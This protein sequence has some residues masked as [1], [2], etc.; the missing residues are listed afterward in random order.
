MD[1]D[2]FLEII[3]QIQNMET[4]DLN[5]VLTFI[6]MEQSAK[7]AIKKDEARKS[8]V[9][10]QSEQPVNPAQRVVL[11]VKDIMDKPFTFSNATMQERVNSDGRYYIV[12]HGA[13]FITFVS[14]NTKLGRLLT[15]RY[16]PDVTFEMTIIPATYNGYPSVKLQTFKILE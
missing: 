11:K 7:Q 9:A 14:A 4:H 15:K 12:K 13:N 5:A 16:N 2:V 3:R 8:E 6:K 1:E 10:E